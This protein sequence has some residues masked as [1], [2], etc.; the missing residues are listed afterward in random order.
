MAQGSE[1]NDGD[2]AAAAAAAV[3]DDD[4]D[5]DGDNDDNDNKYIQYTF[6]KCLINNQLITSASYS[7]RNAT[8][9]IA[10]YLQCSFNIE[11]A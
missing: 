7:Q 2:A 8:F 9:Y 3:A 5:D 10:H 4:D 1:S 11:L 6:Y